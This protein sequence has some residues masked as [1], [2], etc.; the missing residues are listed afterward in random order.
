VTR[1]LVIGASRGIGLESVKALLAAGHDVRAFARQPEAMGLSDARLET[2]AGD[3]TDAAALRNA[4][5]GMEAVVISLGVSLRS[6]ALVRPV[7]LFS[8]ATAALLLVMTELGVRRLIA[9]TG[10]GAGD[11]ADKLSLAEWFPYRAVMGRV[12]DDKARQEALIKDS[13]VDWT[14]VRPGILTN[15][16]AKGRYQV[17]VDRETWRN[18]VIARADV[19]HFIVEDLATGAHVGQAPVLVY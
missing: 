2:F 14:I 13:A 18:G 9:V 10:F 7:T 15:G 1:V 16:S 4:L 5:A 12:Y 8:D 19:A 6:S 17:L 3:A 11:S